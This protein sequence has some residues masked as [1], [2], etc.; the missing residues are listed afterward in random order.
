MNWNKLKNYCEANNVTLDKAM[1]LMVTYVN[2]NGFRTRWLEERLDMYA[3]ERI[4]QKER[5]YDHVFGSKI[6]AVR[7]VVESKEFKEKYEKI[8]KSKNDPVF[9]LNKLITDKRGRIIMAMKNAFKKNGY[10]YII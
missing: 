8:P 2:K 5:G 1:N 9:V 7:A 6:E 3:K 4:K 10:D